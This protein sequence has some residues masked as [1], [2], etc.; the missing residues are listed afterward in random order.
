MGK[1]VKLAKA[2][3]NVVFLDHAVEDT[4][5]MSPPE[6]SFTGGGGGGGE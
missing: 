2:C 5:R 4:Q 1:S 6:G 3:S